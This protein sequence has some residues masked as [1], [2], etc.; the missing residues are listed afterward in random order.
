MPIDS[1]YWDSLYIWSERF[2]SFILQDSKSLGTPAI[3]YS[4]A[5]HL[6]NSIWDL[7]ALILLVIFMQN[8]LPTEKN[9]SICKSKKT[10]QE[11]PK[12]GKPVCK[13]ISYS[14]LQHSSLF[15]GWVKLIF[16]EE[17]GMF[18]AVVLI[19]AITVLS[20]HSAHSLGLIISQWLFVFSLKFHYRTA[21]GQRILKDTPSWALHYITVISKRVFF[22]H[23]PHTS[24]THSIYFLHAI[25]SPL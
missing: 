15:V 4:I 1:D 22:F 9:E 2:M 19:F 8:P 10:A 25:M 17:R 23:S 21:R 20:L 14:P 11:N 13:H 7:C 12:S 3:A 18:S 16:S 24:K 6:E 5:M